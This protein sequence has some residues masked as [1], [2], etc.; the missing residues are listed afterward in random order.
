MTK[1]RR[2]ARRA[3]LA[4]SARKVGAAVRAPSPGRRAVRMGRKLA[5]DPDVRAKALR[6][7]IIAASALGGPAGLAIAT[8]ATSPGSQAKAKRIVS[9]RRAKRAK[10]RS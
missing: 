3:K 2:Q 5:Q 1:S 8:A 4:G 9:K 10:R 6:A 7:G